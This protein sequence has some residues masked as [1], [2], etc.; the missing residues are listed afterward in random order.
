MAEDKS[1]RIRP[2]TIDA[3]ASWIES[4]G[5]V[6]P[7]NAR[8]IAEEVLRLFLADIIA[9]GSTLSIACPGSPGTPPPTNEADG[10]ESGNAQR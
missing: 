5:P 6:G 7:L 9:A 1:I 2:E 4:D 3:A 8:R 10:S